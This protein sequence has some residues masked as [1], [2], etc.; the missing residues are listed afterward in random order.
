[1]ITQEFKERY[2]LLYYGQ[3]VLLVHT[4]EPILNLNKRTFHYDFCWKS[5]KLRLRSLES[6]TDEEAVEVARIERWDGE[7]TVK[8]LDSVVYVYGKYSDYHIKIFTGIGFV[9]TYADILESAGGV[10]VCT[11]DYLRSR[12]FALPYLGVAVEE[13]VKEGFVEIAG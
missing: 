13:M 6:I 7:L 12:S 2:A 9:D 1:M 8:R 3:N 11:Y 10:S 5:A 4:S